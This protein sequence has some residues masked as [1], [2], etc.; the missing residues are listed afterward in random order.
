MVGLVVGLI[1]LRWAW[2]WSVV[3][4][5]GLSMGWSWW[6]GVVVE[7]KWEVGR[8]AKYKYPQK[9]PSPDRLIVQLQH[10]KI[11]ACPEKTTIIQRAK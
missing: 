5:V 11:N 4:F 6:C 3:L 9:E 10:S 1:V 7:R 8:K 2:W